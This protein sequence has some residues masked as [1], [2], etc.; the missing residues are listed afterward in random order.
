[1]LDRDASVVTRA[2]SGVEAERA[3]SARRF[4]R[5]SSGQIGAVFLTAVL[6]YGGARI[7]LLPALV[8]GQVTPF[9][10]P[11]GIAVACLAMFGLRVWP[12]VAIASFAVNAPLGPTL[13]AVI[14]IAA[15]NTVAP[16]VAVLVL[17]GLGAV[18]EL[19]RLR[20]AVLFVFAGVSSM[21]ISATWG[22][23]MLRLAGGVAA[24]HVWSTWSVWWT[25]D[26]MGVLVV[27]PVLL[28]LPRIRQLHALAPVRLIE[29]VALLGLVAAV[30]RYYTVT[31]S[32]AVLLICPLLV[33]SAV[34][35]RQV[36]AAL[37]TLEVSV[38]ASAATATGHGAFAHGGV[39]H[40]MLVLQ[41][42]NASIALT[43]LLLTAAITQL[44]DSRRDLAIANLLLAERIEQ[45][46]AELDHDRRRIA[47]LADRQRI[48]TQLHDTVLQRLF[49]VG[50]AVEAAAMKS[51]PQNRLQL[52]RVVDELDTTIK[53]LAVAIYQVDLDGPESTVR[54]AVEHVIAATTHPLGLMPA[55]ALHGDLE[56]IPLALRPQTLAALHEGLIDLAGN[57][58]ARHVAVSLAVSGDEIT[59]CI[60]V[61]H[62]AMRPPVPREGLRRADARA[63]RLG[64]TCTWQS[65]P[66][67][68]RVEL[69]FPM[70]TAAP[71]GDV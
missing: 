62:L 36:G 45:R 61:D 34:R 31:G 7:G 46:G 43:G 27:A 23:A 54:D 52:N 71:T 17:R 32:P 4:P 20:D 49:G 42:F 14:G 16:L 48:A 41:L 29:G 53:D 44:D 66:H 59:V 47:V 2:G 64:G 13:P 18:I 70:G 33:W 6:Y 65:S 55:L 28:A 8:R 26:A 39:L 51:D 25:G 10:P 60:T 57:A 38:F 9:W 1:M 30:M 69:R 24:D 68:S 58:N 67:T 63:R 22:T 19:G 50:T 12:G 56:R 15:G 40:S 35:F 21:L 5:L 3:H 37:V 11:T